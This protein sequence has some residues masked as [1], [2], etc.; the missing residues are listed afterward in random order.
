MERTCSR[1][2]SPVERVITWDEA[3]EPEI[4]FPCT[5]NSCPDSAY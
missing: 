4:S 3:D 2:G 1:C 5:N